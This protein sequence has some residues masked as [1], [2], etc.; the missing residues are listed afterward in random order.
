M[1]AA[2][3]YKADSYVVG[4]STVET[5]YL[6]CVEATL[7]PVESGALAAKNTL[8]DVYVFNQ[9]NN[10]LLFWRKIDSGDPI[11]GSC[12]FVLTPQQHQAQ[13]KVTIV[14]RCS[15][16]GYYGLNYN[17]PAAPPDYKTAVVAYNGAKLCGGVPVTRP[18]IAPSASGGQG[19]MGI[20]HRPNI[21][22]QSDTLVR[23]FLGGQLNGTC[24]HPRFADN[25]YVIGGALFD[26]NGN[27]ISAPQPI[28]YSTAANHEI[29]FPVAS[30]AASKIKVLR[31][32]LF[33]SLQGRLM[34]FLDVA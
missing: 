18:Y 5:R 20:L 3:Y 25:H 21:I 2:Q 34:S 8:T 24:K 1:V 23:S 11:A 19:D 29:A 27:M 13:L 15:A 6:L 26:Q 7:H 33:D 30:L 4:A 16:N 12:M 10:E 31:V 32:V 17:L 28:L 22:I 14:A 9:A